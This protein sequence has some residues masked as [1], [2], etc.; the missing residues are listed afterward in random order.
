MRLRVLKICPQ[1]TPATCSP[2]HVSVSVL[3]SRHLAGSG[4]SIPLA[5][6]RHE[7]FA[8]QMPSRLI[9]R[10]GIY[11]LKGKRVSGPQGC[12]SLGRGTA[13]L[14]SPGLTHI[15][16]CWIHSTTRSPTSSSK[17]RICSSVS[18]GMTLQWVAKNPTEDIQQQSLAWSLVPQWSPRKHLAL[19]EDPG[20]APL[21]LCSWRGVHLFRSP[22]HPEQGWPVLP[23]GYDGNYG[24]WLLRLG[25]KRH[26]GSCPAA[27]TSPA[28][29][30]ASCRVLRTLKQFYGEIQMARSWDPCQ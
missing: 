19:P 6:W 25:H 28:L 10:R 30:E 3:S 15:C 21:T 2:E 16:V 14:V 13:N 20:G 11:S 7:Q 18:E 5:E 26:C 27:F 22:S 24:T 23:T 4:H 17:G 8:C 12:F 9:H 1:M 29:G